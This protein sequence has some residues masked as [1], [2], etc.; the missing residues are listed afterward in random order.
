M[1]I[2]IGKAVMF[3]LLTVEYGHSTFSTV[4][5]YI[6]LRFDTV[7]WKEYIPYIL[8]NLNK[9]IIGAIIV[10]I[11]IQLICLDSKTAINTCTLKFFRWRLKNEKNYF[12]NCTD[13]DFF[14]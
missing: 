13:I 10:V 7:Y 6:I 3:F 5:E 11:W 9:E 4:K 14:H 1:A 2:V 8:N 12:I